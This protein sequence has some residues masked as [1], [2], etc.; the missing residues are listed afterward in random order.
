MFFNISIQ[1]IIHKDFCKPGSSKTQQ[2]RRVPF[3]KQASVFSQSKTQK[4]R[5][6][7]PVE[8]EDAGDW[9]VRAGRGRVQEQSVFRIEVSF[10][11]SG[12]CKLDQHVL[13]IVAGNT[14]V[15]QCLNCQITRYIEHSPEMWIHYTNEVVLLFKLTDIKTSKPT[16]SFRFA[17]LNPSL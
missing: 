9:P 16:F 12:Q 14:V 17:T 7:M 6:H 4:Q 10:E 2:H 8:H 13:H 15:I 1:T 11:S 5:L 3:L